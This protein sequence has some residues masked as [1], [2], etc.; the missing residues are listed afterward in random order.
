MKKGFSNAVTVLRE[1]FNRAR[2]NTPSILFID[3]IESIAPSRSYSPSELVGQ[4]LNEMDGMKSISGVVVV[5]ATNKPSML[6]T[7][8]LRPGRFDKIFY[9]GPPDKKAR[10]DIFKINLGEFADKLNPDSFASLTD[11]FSGADIASICQEVKMVLLRDKLAGRE[12]KTSDDLVIGVIKKRRPSITK[13]LL[14]EY[15]EFLI[16]YGE[17]R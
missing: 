6:D 12:P 4:L 7:A 14:R 17:R 10:E 13:D 11:G 1:S 5:A 15:Q 2:E 8:I 9:I 16:E 3:E